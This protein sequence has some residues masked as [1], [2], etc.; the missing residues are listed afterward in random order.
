MS[1][2]NYYQCSAM[3]AYAVIASL[4]IYVQDGRT[5]ESLQ[6]TSTPVLQAEE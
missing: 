5:D 3:V 6:V 1:E 4:L 2:S